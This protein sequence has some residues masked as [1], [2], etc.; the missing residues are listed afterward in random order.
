MAWH[1][2][3][4]VR[5]ESRYPAKSR[6]LNAELCQI[7]VYL[8]APTVIEKTMK[9]MADAPTQEEQLEY[10]R[11]LRVLKRGWTLQQREDYFRWLLKAAHFKGGSSMAKFILRIR[12]DAID[13]LSDQEKKDLK[14]ILEEKPPEKAPITGKV[15]PV[16]K[17]YKLDD[18]LP[19]L[20]KGLTKKRDFDKGRRYFAEARCFVC[21]RF[22]S[23]GG[24][25]GPDLT[26]I[27]GRFGVKDLLTSIVEPSKEISDQYAA[28]EVTT[29]KG[30]KISG[31]IINLGQD[32]KTAEEVFMINTNMEDPN[33][34][35]TVK[36]KDV[37][38][39]KTSKLSMM[40]AGL[41]DGFKEEE[42]VDLMAYLL[43]RGDRKH[44]MFQ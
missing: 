19:S 14:A 1:E 24:S 37:D 25:M 26:G 17:N 28:V 3:C 31:R 9:L 10:G 42:I 29:N 23:E 35:A 36:R 21:H 38:E 34:I 40:P 41:L 18:L 11:S 6:E 20:E 8:E 33:A 7:L 2:T 43:S 27:A 39:M 30:R 16:V 32:R 15:R 13:S 4:K 22:D 44:K 5:F 12:N